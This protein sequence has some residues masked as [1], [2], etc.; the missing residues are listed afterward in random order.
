MSCDFFIIKY[1]SHDKIV[2]YE[3]RKSVIVLNFGII[4]TGDS[5][6]CYS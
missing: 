6:E 1:L 3:K 4:K 5:D 2:A